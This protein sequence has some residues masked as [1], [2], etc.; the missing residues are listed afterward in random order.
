MLVDLNHICNQE[1][2]NLE[3]VENVKKVNASGNV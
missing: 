1:K 3:D 2:I